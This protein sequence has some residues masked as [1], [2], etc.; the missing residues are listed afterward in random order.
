[1]T[2]KLIV[3][4]IL[5]YLLTGCSDMTDI[6]NN[7]KD[8]VYNNEENA[9]MNYSLT[10]INSFKFPA[11]VKIMDAN[12][13]KIIY[14]SIKQN[15]N[16]GSVNKRA[17]LSTE[18]L[19][20]HDMRSDETTE[21]MSVGNNEDVYCFDTIQRGED[22]FTSLIKE[23][24]DS[25]V[26]DYTINFIEN[27]ISKVIDKGIWD[28]T[29]V[30]G[31]S[32]YF[33]KFNKN[34]IAYS[35][36]KTD[37]VTGE[38]I[39]GI[40]FIY[41]DA[42]DNKTLVLDDIIFLDGKIKSNGNELLLLAKDNKEKHASFYI[43]D[44]KGIKNK[45]PFPENWRIYEYEMLKDGIVMV[46][47][48][49]VKNNDYSKSQR[50]T[51]YLPFD[52]AESYQFCTNIY[53]GVSTLGNDIKVLSDQNGNEVLF[54]NSSGNLAFYSIR[55]GNIS[56]QNIEKEISKDIRVTKMDNKSVVIS[57]NADKKLWL[58]T[59]E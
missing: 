15:F 7:I 37:E 12:S 55:K 59:I 23:R 34:I 21:I 26:I 32:L 16:K 25:M 52:K 14:Q 58:L 46:I 33:Q 8:A 57:S 41:E 44:E 40:A 54:R 11:Y 4:L 1:M 31:N 24:E 19:F 49:N 56:C 27:G 43:L 39:N 20:M 29:S 38:Y 18:K 53:R 42:L 22:I 13:S 51:V 3:I 36:I 6:Q 30:Y 45:I 5:L 9:I 48:D 17:Y 47:A 35:Y 10:E 50:R 28:E 2:K